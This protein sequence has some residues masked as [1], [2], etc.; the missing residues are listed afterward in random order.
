MTRREK[1]RAYMARMA[2]T[3][4]PKLALQQGLYVKPP[5]AIS[6]HI[7]QR[8]EIEPTAH[9]LIVGGIGAGK[10]T[11]LLTVQ[12]QLTSVEDV[13]AEYVDVSEKQDLMK[14]RP[15]S[16]VA[17]AGMYLQSL[18]PEPPKEVRLNWNFFGHWSKGYWIHPN[19]M[20]PDDDDGSEWHPGIL[21]PPQNPWTDIP[22]HHVSL[23]R[24]ASTELARQ[25]K[26]PILLFD[27]LDRMTDLQSFTKIVEQ[28]IAAL[29][30][31][32]IGVVLI[33]PIR[34]LSGFGRLEVEHFDY[35]HV[36]SPVDVAHDEQG[37]AFLLEVLR[38]RAEP[39][40]L[41]DAAAQ[42]LVHLSGGV[43]RELIHLAKSA[44]Q[45]AYRQ[46]AEAIDAEHVDI[47]ANGYGRS[48]LVGLKQA[49][50]DTLKHLR[51][52]GGFVRV[53]ESDLALMATRRILEYHSSTSP[54]RFAVHPTIAPLLDQVAGSP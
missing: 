4:D 26:I 44:G 54:V 48:L 12:Q 2:A 3:A 14:A 25:G 42:R 9:Q 6:E 41:T 15:G 31:A 37:R 30:W 13:R 35:L 17:L 27:S 21:T 46:G 16:L 40:I 38:R 23:L 36:Q 1:F 33:A 51:T 20:Y 45:T 10:T 7:V 18:L 22:D 28:D 19:E 47:A 52:T 11:Q 32:K 24:E 53:S 39:E 29:R 8:F 34:S 5:D 49:E 43:L 50:I